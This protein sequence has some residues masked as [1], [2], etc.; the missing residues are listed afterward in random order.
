MAA[1]CPPRRCGDLSSCVGEGWWVS[2]SGKVCVSGQVGVR[3]GLYFCVNPIR[4]RS[5][6]SVLPSL[7]ICSFGGHV[8][9][10]Y[11]L[12]RRILYDCPCKRKVLFTYHSQ[13]VYMSLRAAFLSQ[14]FP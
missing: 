7:Y 4:V 12:R 11:S 3:A 9:I 2:L 13:G 14:V 8:C 10:C 1:A 6:L 5:P